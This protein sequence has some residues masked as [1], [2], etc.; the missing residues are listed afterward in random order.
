MFLEISSSYEP[1]KP[2]EFLPLTED[3][4]RAFVFY[5]PTCEWS[6]PFALRIKDL[7]SELALNLPVHIIDMSGVLQNSRSNEE[8]SS[9]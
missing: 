5:N 1:R 2:A 3:K 6:F 4:G 9:L 8:M 7:L